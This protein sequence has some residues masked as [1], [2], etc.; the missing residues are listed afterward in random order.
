M[1]PVIPQRVLIATQNSGKVR[2]FR[3]LFE[4]IPAQFVGLEELPHVDAP[5]E[6]GATF[7]D[8]ARLKARYYSEHFHSTALADDS[9]LVVDVLDG[10]PGFTQLDMAV[11]G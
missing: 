10:A 6:D 1:N 2:E 9:G 5:S 8:N 11:M 3:R 7:L 4:H